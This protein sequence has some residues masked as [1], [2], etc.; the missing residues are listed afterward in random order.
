VQVQHLQKRHIQRQG[1][2]TREA[3]EP[4]T[5]VSIAQV[6]KGVGPSMSLLGQLSSEE[7]PGASAAP[8]AAAAAATAADDAGRRLQKLDIKST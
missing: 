7:A 6:W 3:R 4:S 8:T 5:S 1:E 2:E